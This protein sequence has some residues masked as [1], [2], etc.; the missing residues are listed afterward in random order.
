MVTDSGIPCVAEP[1]V[2]LIVTTKVPVGAVATG[3]GTS[4]LKLANVMPVPVTFASNGPQEQMMRGG[5]DCVRVMC[6]VP[7]KPFSG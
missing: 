7:V 6:T 4:R 1:L 2:P 3:F 5:R